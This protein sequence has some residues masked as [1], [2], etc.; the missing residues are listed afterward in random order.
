MLLRVSLGFAKLPDTGL[1]MYLRAVAAAKQVL[2]DDKLSQS[3][4][5]VGKYG[6]S[7]FVSYE[8]LANVLA[9]AEQPREAMKNARMAENI[10]MAF[11][12]GDVNN[13]E[14]VLDEISVL[15]DKQKIFTLEGK[16]DEA[17]KNVEKALG[18][19]KECYRLD[20][21]NVEAISCIGYLSLDAIRVLDKLGR[22]NDTETHR[23]IFQNYERLFRDKFG[24]EWTFGF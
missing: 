22:R 23:Q 18:L 6:R 12:K 1:Q 10:I 15:N 20:Q 13:R 14:T 21:T 11:R 9:K 4:T 7:L 2:E 3:G 24:R 8:N 5:P 19:A 16:L 17:F